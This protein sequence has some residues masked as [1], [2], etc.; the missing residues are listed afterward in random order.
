[1]LILTFEAM[2]WASQKHG[3]IYTANFVVYEDRR[4]REGGCMNLEELKDEIALC[5]KCKLS[6]TRTCTV[7]GEGALGKIMIVSEGP[8]IEEDKE[9][10][11][12]MGRS[13]GLL[14]AILSKE[15]GIKRENIYITNTVK[16]RA[17]VDLKFEKDRAPDEEETMA[18]LPFL[19]TEV[20]LVKPRVIVT[21]GGHAMKTLL[22]TKDGITKV[23]GEWGEYRGVPVM[24]VYHPSYILRNGG[25]NSPTY[26]TVVND[27][28]KIAPLVRKHNKS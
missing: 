17:T 23:H 3:K 13:G 7:P 6:T 24:P 15:L 9:G 14:N 19:E 16:C 20:E 10:R 27:L 25:I 12:F 28:L 1:M 18:C 11:P 8:G 5:Q 4:F 26:K 2:L 22:E 21:L